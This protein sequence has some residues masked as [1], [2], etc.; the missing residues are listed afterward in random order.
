MAQLPSIPTGGSSLY[1]GDFAKPLYGITQNLTSAMI[2]QYERRKKEGDQDRAALLKALSFEAIENASDKASRMLLD[3]YSAVE[4]KWTQRYYENGLKLS[5]KD[6]F[7]LERDKRKLDQMSAKVRGN[8]SNAMLVQNELLKNGDQ[9]NKRSMKNWLD[10][11]QQG[12]IGLEDPSTILVPKIDVTGIVKKKYHSVLSDSDNFEIKRGQYDP[13]TGQV[14]TWRTNER[15][16]ESA[17]QRIMSDPDIVQA[18]NDPDEGQENLEALNQILDMYKINESPRPEAAKRTEVDAWERM[19]LTPEQKRIKE[20]TGTTVNDDIANI[21][22]HID[23][24]VTNAFAGD[25]GALD[26]FGKKGAARINRDGSI[27]ISYQSGGKTKRATLEP[28]RPEDT[29]QVANQKKMA[30]ANFL[31]PN[32]LK[33]RTLNPNLFTKT[34]DEAEVTT[35]SKYSEVEDAQRLF[36]AKKGETVELNIDGEPSEFT[37][38]SNSHVNEIINRMK[39]IFPEDTFKYETFGYGFTWKSGDESKTFDLKKDSDRKELQNLIEEKVGTIDPR[40]ASAPME[41]QMEER[42]EGMSE[43]RNST[44]SDIEKWGAE[45]IDDYIA[46]KRVSDKEELRRNLYSLGITDEDIKNLYNTKSTAF[47]GV[48]KGGF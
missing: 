37:A 15:F 20:R 46:K 22:S 11:Q 38:Y 18:I 10:F 34:M 4:D 8:V 25:R 16:I 41:Q 44:L 9:Y 3:E 1:L 36:D 33:G 27:E 40:S 48:P 43:L 13:Q 39:E 7:E 2:D 23:T 32:M 31:D 45:S 5:D 30:L 14:Q 26:V 21:H 24:L 42:E 29:P 47:K 12:K 35:P 6:Y 28:P 19:N 17:K